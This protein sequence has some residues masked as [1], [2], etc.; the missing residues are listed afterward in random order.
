MVQ[1]IGQGRV[2]PPSA[3]Q[4]LGMGLSRAAGGLIEHLSQQQQMNQSNQ[5]INQENEAAKRLG[6]DL[7][8]ITD[9]KIRQ[10]IFSS[11]LKGRNLQDV[12]LLK[13][14]GK[15][16]QQQEKMSYLSQFFGGG[17]PQGQEET[18]GMQGAG[19]GQ[20]GQ[21]GF[22]VSQL[23][24]AQIAQV[25]SIDPNVGRALSHAKDVA[26]RE[27]RA[28]REFL[29]TQEQRSPEK[30]REK[31]VTGAQ[32]TADIKYNQ[33]LQSA[34]KQHEIKT[35]TLNRLEE[36]NKKGVTGKPYEKLLEKFG[37]VNLTSE[38]RREFS[39]ETKNSR[40]LKI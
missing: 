14:Q 38:G 23:S 13:Q 31:Q 39:A 29:A 27:K 12:E 24:D 9:P 21:G 10:E 20:M 7:S 35:Q 6:L 4:R 1:I 36:L 5:M 40:L 26:L 37:L 19:Q 30:I 22:D 11:A 33:E 16:R 8:G 15:Q 34:H 17:E 18:Q 3:S 32:A 28:E 25:N 2:K